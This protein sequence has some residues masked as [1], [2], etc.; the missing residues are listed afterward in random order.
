MFVLLQNSDKPFFIS[1]IYFVHSPLENNFKCLR[2]AFDFF[3][4][5]Y[6]KLDWRT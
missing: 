6:N 4:S 2:I 3:Y 5:E 1:F